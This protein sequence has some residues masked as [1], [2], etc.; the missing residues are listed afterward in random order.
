MCFLVIFLSY[1][2]IYSVNQVVNTDKLDN[3]LSLLCFICLCIFACKITELI[4]GSELTTC[5]SSFSNE[6][7]L[8]QV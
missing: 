6:N 8:G 1:L 5:T 7:P 3:A 4:S 2:L